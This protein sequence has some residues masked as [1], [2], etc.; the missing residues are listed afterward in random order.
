MTLRI[1]LVEPEAEELLFLQD[2]LREVE[3]ERLLPEWPKIEPLCAAT[4]AEAQRIL[5]TS[6][7]QVI[8]LGL[9]GDD[10]EADG[11]CAFR[12]AQAI[13]PDVPV[14]LLLSSAGEELAA[15]LMR[16]GAED[17]LLKRE[18]DCAPLA[19]ALRNA[20]LRHRQLSA[21]RAAAHADSLTGLPNRAGF[22][23]IAERDRK[24]AERLNRRWMLLVAEPRN[25]AALSRALGEQRRDLELVEAAEQ[26]RSIA[27]PADLVARIGERHF[28]FSVFD[29]DVETAEEA[30]VRIRAAAAEHRI[31]IGASIFDFDRPLSLDAMLEQA[32]ADLPQR[33][34]TRPPETS[35]VA[36]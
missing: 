25:L 2:V 3:E 11:D 22:L 15:R 4:W 24:L 36:V 32:M 13:A 5:A 9:Q 6:P 19:H 34:E 35:K 7:P 12:S 16:E 8:L 23:A 28:A 26:L 21:A 33:R 29:G 10:L 27:T 20:V 30:W 31:D 1:L 18:V 14:I 17:F